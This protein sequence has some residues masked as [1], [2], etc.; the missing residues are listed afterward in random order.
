MKK[1]FLF[2]LALSAVSICAA[3]QAPS[4]SPAANKIVRKIKILHADPQLIALILSGKVKFTT[5][6]EISTLR[7]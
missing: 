5:P 6:P 3:Q 7:R 4:P 1:F 2:A